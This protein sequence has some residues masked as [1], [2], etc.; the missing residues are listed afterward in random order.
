MQPWR[1]TSKAQAIPTMP[2]LFGSVALK[3]VAARSLQRGMAARTLKEFRSH[4]TQALD[5]FNL[6]GFLTQENQTH[7]HTL[8]VPLLHFL[9]GAMIR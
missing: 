6:Q 1:A 3:I 5:S 4:M 7:T 2:M 9:H 8:V